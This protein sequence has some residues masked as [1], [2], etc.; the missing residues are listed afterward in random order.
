MSHQV[1]GFISPGKNQ[2]RKRTTLT[3]QHLQYLDVR[4]RLFQ[5]YRKIPIILNFLYVT[6]SHT[7][8]MALF[9]FFLSFEL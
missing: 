3:G 8:P 5:V 9:N 2:G 4:N 6:L 7:H 1:M